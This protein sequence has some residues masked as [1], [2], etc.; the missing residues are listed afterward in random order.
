MSKALGSWSGMR[1]YLEQEMLASS[2]RG[3]VRYNCTRYVGMDDTHIFEVWV[4]G[5]PVKRF[6]METLQTYFI[7]NGYREKD[8]R[9]ADTDGIVGYWSG[10]WD[11]VWKTPM[12]ART[13]YTGSEFC[14]AL[15]EYRNQSIQDSVR[16]DDP[17]QRMFAILDRRVGK[18]SLLRIKE[19]IA[20]QP[21][22]LQAFYR[23]RME[24]EG[25]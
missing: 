20:R 2:L 13:E 12:E 8:P 23:L 1:K 25:L 18:R 21:D 22:W 7:D 17:I 9:E 16:S 14:S 3:R 5:K 24:A 19:E 4:D 15:D 10:F 6:S 11:T